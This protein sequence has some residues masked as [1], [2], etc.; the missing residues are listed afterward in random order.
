MSR[1]LGGRK[2]CGRQ[3]GRSDALGECLRPCVRDP[4]STC[5]PQAPQTPRNSHRGLEDGGTEQE[6]GIVLGVS[7]HCRAPRDCLT[8]TWQP[9]CRLADGPVLEESRGAALRS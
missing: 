2:G 9:L 4:T 7:P 1:S 3:D 8:P 5:H 6:L